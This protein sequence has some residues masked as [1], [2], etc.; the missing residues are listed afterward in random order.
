MEKAFPFM[1]L[2]SSLKKEFVVKHRVVRTLLLFS[3]LVSIGAS[4]SA[5]N[6]SN[7]GTDFWVGFM[8]H[9]NGTS[10]SMYLYITSD[11]NTTGTVSIPGQSWSK[12]FTVTANSMT[13]VQIPTSTAY[14]SCSDCVQ[15]RGIHVT[16]DLPIVV[17]AHIYHQYC[18]DA[19]LVLPTPT[20]G[21]EYYAMS[22]EQLQS[23]GR[24]QFMII[25]N[26][27]DTKVRI[28]PTITLQGASG[29]RAANKSY[30]ITLDAGEV[31]QG[32]AKSSGAIQDVTGTHIEVIDTGATANCRTVSVFSG[33]SDTYLLCGSPGGGLNS[34]DNLYQQL[35]PT[36][37]WGTR[38]ITIPFKSRS[39]DHLRILAAE[40]NTQVIIN[41]E[42]GPPTVTTLDAGDIYN[43][44]DVSTTKYILA[45][46]P[47]CVAQYQTS[48]K[49][50][51]DGDPSMTILNPI[52]QT[53][54]NITVYSSEYED[55]EKHFINVIIPNGGVGSFR[56]DGKTASFTKVPKNQAYSYAQITVT[57][58]NHSLSSSEGFLAIAY[59]FADYESY[60]YSAGA[61]VRD[62]TAQIDLKNS[63]QNEVNSLCLGQTADFEGNAEYQVSQWI[64]D[65]GDGT[66]DTAQKV[67]HTYADTG[68][69]VV[70]LYTYKVLFDGCSTYDSTEMEI[71]VNALPT[72]DFVSS[73]KCEKSTVFYT[74]SS[75]VPSSETILSRQWI[76]HDKSTKYATNSS[77]YYDTSGQFDVTLVTK[78]TVQCA[79]TLTKTITINPLPVAAFE[80]DDI[81][82]KDTNLFTN[83]STVRLG[84]IDVNKWYFGDTDSSDLTSPKHYYADSGTFEVL[85]V[86]T[87]DS[88]CVASHKDTVVKYPKFTIDYSYQDTCAGLSVNF[89]N[90]STTD[91]LT[92]QDFVWK[93]PGSQEFTTNTVDYQF[94]N[95]GSYDV[96]LV[97]SLDTVCRDSVMK[98]V[99]VDPN[100]QADFSVNSSCLE[101]SI[102]FTNTSS[103]SAGSVVESNWDFDDGL[104]GSEPIE[105]VKYASKGA[106]DVQLITITDKGCADTVSKTIVV[107]EPKI[108][109]FQKPLMC[110]DQEGKITVNL[111]LDGDSIVSW[112]WFSEGFTSTT[113]TL[114]FKS[115]T[116]GRFEVTL[117][118]ITKYNCKIAHVDSIDVWTIPEASFT[119][120]PICLGEDL[121]PNNTSTIQNGES[122]A[123]HSWYLNNSLVSTNQS[124]TLKTNLVGTNNIRLIVTSP[125]GCNDAHA[126]TV[127]VYPLPVPTFTYMDTCLGQT[128]TFTSGATI[129]SGTISS[130]QWRYNDNTTAFGNQVSRVFNTPAEYSIVLIVMSDQGC[131][132]SLSRSL[133]IAPTPNLSL[134]V[135]N[136]TGCEPFTPE[137]SNTS[138][139]LT[140]TITGYE[141]DF[142]D[143]NTA[144]G[145]SPT[146]TYPNAGLYTVTL[147]AETD[148]GCRDTLVYGTQIDV[149]PKPLAAFSFTP[150]VPSL[151]YPDISLLNESSPDAQT[152]EWSITDGSQ[153]STRD[154]N[155]T[156]AEPGDYIATLIAIA[157][158]GC[159][160]TSVQDIY[161][162]QDFFLHAPTAF[163]PNKDLVNDLFGISGMVS[164][165]QGYS[166]SIFNMWGELIFYSENPI[167]KWDGT[168]LGKEIHT[169]SFPYV[170]RYQNI[171]TE[172]WETINGVVHIMR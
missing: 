113:D 25:A 53:L 32:R 155:H 120:S 169:G 41:N 103:L 89:V 119:I 38:F 16:S 147:M 133:T 131:V 153:F 64:W 88:N 72:A 98:T 43:V 33:S 95:T 110:Q 117:N 31:Y 67:K 14:V 134:T 8:N 13:L 70:T 75:T 66:R 28:T 29:D 1:H 37:S 104:T 163:S 17:Y 36:R 26:K 21:K 170:V 68:D 77:Y 44:K 12:S 142:G 97:G 146:H 164:S 51:G 118:A 54:K 6:S 47:I 5:Q 93:F 39:V 159:R 11:S 7:K 30:E 27:D 23:G 80:A 152:F 171:E 102:T 46:K 148:A 106:K 96:W 123:S 35:Y 18:S 9:R 172:R 136:A 132:D 57:K 149:Q 125:K 24:S 81:C 140:G 19:T 74:D 105:K 141:W 55:I 40:D 82:F 137:F 73:L 15:D 63:A 34:R 3:F 166:M 100:I 126:T 92:L 114:K 45:G 130:E 78:T 116:T 60:G 151:L 167:E 162:K 10:A 144:T 115:S 99:V 94:A 127:D 168:Y 150:E 135:T 158:N 22:Y 48:R 56:I 138:T 49:C 84:D 42:S 145:L 90:T 101:D 76:F 59:G 52:E 91:G 108:T 61:N 20:T 160:D 85:L 71:R 154:V 79:D 50:G 86:V 111:D 122:I 65:Y 2:F 128:T 161:V 69:Y 124:P 83:T 4:A 165:V 107:Y 143:G 139:V 129:T 121:V 156:F 58:G 109:S 157:A 112:D 62:L 87:T